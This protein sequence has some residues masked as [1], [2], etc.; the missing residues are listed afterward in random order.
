MCLRVPSSLARDLTRLILSAGHLQLH[1]RR[2]HRGAPIRDE[3][4]HRH[5]EQHALQH[6]ASAAHGQEHGQPVGCERLTAERPG[7]HP[8]RIVRL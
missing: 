6:P 7:L 4:P 3:L 8:P 1:P 2:G 5:H